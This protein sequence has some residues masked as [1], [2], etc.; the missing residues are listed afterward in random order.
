MLWV[1]VVGADELSL[2]FLLGGC[3][4]CARDR[5]L[6]M[7]FVG[8]VE[9]KYVAGWYAEGSGPQL[10]RLL[11]SQSGAVAR[12]RSC[13]L[14]AVVVWVVDR[15]KNKTTQQDEQSVPC[16]TDPRQK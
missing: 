4:C 2:R 13:R 5:V 6:A 3:W 7:M 14:V 12:W 1:D 11:V 9:Y 8:A 16:T 15:G 10:Y